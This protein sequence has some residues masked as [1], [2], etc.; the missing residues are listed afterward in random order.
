MAV[1]QANEQAFRLINGL[2]PD[3]TVTP[4][5]KVKLYVDPGASAATTA[6]AA[7]AVSIK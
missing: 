3:E 4:G 2:R 5:Q 6:A 1:P 7:T